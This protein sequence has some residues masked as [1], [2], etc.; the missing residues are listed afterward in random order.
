MSAPSVVSCPKCATRLKVDPSRA[1][2]CPKCGTLLS[3]PPPTRPSPPAAAAT[4]DADDHEPTRG[5][6]G[7][8]VGTVAGLII[9]AGIVGA[10]FYLRDWKMRRDG[11][12]KPAEGD[13]PAAG[14][15]PADEPGVP[16]FLPDPTSPRELSGD[17]VYQ[18]L[19]RS[20]AFIVTPRGHGSG[21]LIDS[22]RRLVL[23]NAH[24]V[25]DNKKVAVLFPFYDRDNQV[26]PDP[27][28][29]RDKAKE[30]GPNATVVAKS[31]IQDL[32]LVQIEQVPIG[33][34]P[35][36][37]SK[38]PA[39][40]GV[41]VYSIGGSG[42]DDKLL[43][44][45]ST[46]T[47]RGRARQEYRG[48]VG[49]LH[50]MV[51]ETQSPVNPGD[52]GGPVVNPRV[53]LV[54]LVAA[55]K[56]RERLVSINIDLTEV[57]A[58]VG[59]YF[60]DQGETWKEPEAEAL[61]PAASLAAV[62]DN[63]I[64]VLK[65][66]K[67]ADRVV[68]A[69]RLGN[70][71]AQARPAVQALLGESTA[72]DPEL[73][74]AIGVALG[75]IG[76]PDAGAEVVLLQALR[77]RSVVARVY[78]VKMFATETAIPPDGVR[79]VTE[80][81]RDE[82]AEVRA[83]AAQAIAKHG[84]KAR[85]V[86]F[87]SLLDG[88]ADKDQAVR[89][90]AAAAIKA[91]GPPEAEDC[92]ALHARLKHADT[93]VRV[94]AATLLVPLTTTGEVAVPL[95]KSLADESPEVRALAARAIGTAG[96]KARAATIGPLLD[97]LA[98]KEQAV[99]EACAAALKVVGGAEPAN[100]PALL[101]RLKHADLRVR[102]AAAGLLSPLTTT[103]D[104]ALAV[105]VPLLA[106]PNTELRLAAVTTLTSEEELLESAASEVLGLLGDPESAVRR[107]V[108][109]SARDLAGKPGVAEKLAERLE[110][111]PDRAVRTVVAESLLGL[112]EAKAANL[113]QFR[114][115]LKDPAPVVR[116]GAARKIGLLGVE[117]VRAV[118]DLAGLIGDEVE[119]VRVAALLALAAMEREAKDVVPAAADLFERP[120][121]EPVLAAAARLLGAT[122][123]DGVRKLETVCVRP[124]PASV[125]EEICRA[126]AKSNSPSGE[127]RVWMMDQA[128]ELSSCREAVAQ[129]LAKHST[130]ATVLQMLR[131]THLYKPR[132]PGE[133]Q[134]TY[135]TDYRV[136]ALATLGKMKVPDVTNSE[137]RRQVLELVEH[138][139]KNDASPEVKAEA[140]IALSKIRSQ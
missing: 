106:D 76:P 72:A 36:G 60:R 17:E 32:A 91:V 133:K 114:R 119:S 121:P 41:T 125:R 7:W 108:A 103:R 31:E 1:S 61:P 34:R 15:K 81:L 137:T 33:V 99:R 122:G 85:P 104:D 65:G 13:Q 10:A 40:T 16:T 23:T 50:A 135:P 130:D 57:R 46:G 37:I 29:Y 35:V 127:M 132:R 129:A 128:E 105:W 83:L 126:F 66:G 131:R 84:T 136:W 124:L 3:S 39:S 2:K 92:S 45:L 77:A 26:I 97:G 102:V 54:G 88:L 118:P 95:I 86:A 63:L 28:P 19:L 44:R 47:V 79:A 110:S 6:H 73:R 64:A 101:E 96:P 138:F 11:A 25:E 22:G 52:S 82:S 20:T 71:R 87:G 78:A 112:T 107:V 67:P 115:F 116:E 100:R 93:R 123:A 42:A 51:L 53:E 9:L 113:P 140:K 14:V 12:A 139:A 80:A 27:G 43:W 49:H 120:T 8:L 48:D 68:A 24:V 69:R 58:F 56:L 30:T 4:R 134:K 38:L 75:Q 109:R 117:A 62:L 94:A 74:T 111:E 90:A 21:V 98:D 55:V 5:P 70:L 59:K 18:R 89:E